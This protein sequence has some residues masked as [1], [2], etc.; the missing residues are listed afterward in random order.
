MNL[1]YTYKIMK[2]DILIKKGMCTERF[3]SGY[4]TLYDMGLVKKNITIEFKELEDNQKS[5]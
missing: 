4:E 2:K 3:K 5:I 1:M